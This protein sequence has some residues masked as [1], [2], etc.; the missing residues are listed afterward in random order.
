MYY[1]HIVYH[2]NTNLNTNLN[3]QSIINLLFNIQIIYFIA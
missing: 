2:F 1:L 3:K